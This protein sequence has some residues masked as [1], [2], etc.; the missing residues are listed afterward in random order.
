M[1]TNS[2]LYTEPKLTAAH[3]TTAATADADTSSFTYSHE[4]VRQ[5]LEDARLDGWEEGYEEGSKKLME[6]YRDGYEARRKLD[7]E[8]EERARK[9]GQLEGYELVIQQG[10]DEERRKWLTEGHGAGLCLS[11]AAH[12]S[13][14]FRGAVLVEDAEA[15]TDAATT[16]DVDI[17]VTPA[18]STVVDATTQV[19]P[20]ADD[21]R[22]T[23]TKKADTAPR[24]DFSTQNQ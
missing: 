23:S 9:E 6:G 3:P 12:A 2:G 7:E 13:A 4:E 5:L 20:A 15:Q 16:V 14:L 21:E 19:T 24:V 11:M 10:K 1:A 8:K 17:Q 22:P 18:T